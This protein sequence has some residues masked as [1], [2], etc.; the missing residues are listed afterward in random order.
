VTIHH[1]LHLTVFSSLFSCFV[2]SHRLL[3]CQA[4]P[5]RSKP[6]YKPTLTDHWFLK[7]KKHKTLLAS[8]KTLFAS[9]HFQTSPNCSTGK[10]ISKIQAA[11]LLVEEVVC[12]M[13]KHHR[14]LGVNS[15]R[16]GQQLNAVLDCLWCFTV[17]LQDC[18]TNQCSNTLAVKLQ[19]T[20]KCS[21]MDRQTYRNIQVLYTIQTGNSCLQGAEWPVFTAADRWGLYA[22]QQPVSFITNT[23]STSLT[24]FRQ[25]LK[26]EL[27]HRCFGPDCVWWLSSLF[28]V[29]LRTRP[30]HCKMSLQSLGF[31]DTSIIFIY[32]NN[33]DDDNTNH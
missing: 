21:P 26:T 29:W 18:Q 6:G 20:L 16:L 25:R 33:D 12:E 14:I 23:S 10:T 27:F 17:Q 30:V 1:N 28:Y 19:S 8:H 2:L 4:G 3:Y 32:N 22:G 13:V 15:V 9:P 5:A 31:Y 7:S 24:V 11:Y